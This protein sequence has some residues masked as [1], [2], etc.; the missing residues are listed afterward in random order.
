MLIE[1]IIR[2]WGLCFILLELIAFVFVA[3]AIGFFMAILLILLSSF[4]GGGLLRLSGIYTLTAMQTRFADP[5]QGIV[6]MLAGFLL[7]IPGF[8]TSTL[9]LACLLPFVGQGIAHWFTTRIH[10][11]GVKKPEGNIIEGEFRREDDKKS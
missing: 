10:P 1:R 8:I 7:F 4:I 3:K 5:A 6:L 9:G 11:P 2:N